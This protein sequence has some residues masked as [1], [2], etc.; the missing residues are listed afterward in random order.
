MY[1]AAFKERIKKWG[2]QGDNN[3]LISKIA[4]HSWDSEPAELKEFYARCANVERINHGKAFPDYKFAPNK[5]GKKRGRPDDGDDDE[6]DPEWDGSSVLGGKRRNRGIEKGLSRSV[7]STPTPLPQGT[8]EY[9]PSSFQASNPHGM[10]SMV[11]FDQWNRPVQYHQIYQP[12]PYGY[13][14]PMQPSIFVQRHPQPQYGMQSDLTS[15]LVG[16]PPSDAPLVNPYGMEPEYAL[17]PELTDD[18]GVEGATYHYGAYPDQIQPH[19]VPRS[20]S[21]MPAAEHE[22][23]HPGMTMLP[24]MDSWALPDPEA[25]AFDAAFDQWGDTN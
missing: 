13:A 24:G 15:A 25:N 8:P 6:S 19:D 2:Q 10:T 23:L 1:R 22:E 3:Q 14:V 16:M 20:H 5:T 4:G 18:F 11:Q 17:D 12:A 21:S 9:H 7:T